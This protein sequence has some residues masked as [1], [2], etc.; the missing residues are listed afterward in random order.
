MTCVYDPHTEPQ[1]KVAGF[2]GFPMSL[3]VVEPL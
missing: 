1:A 2:D 3:D